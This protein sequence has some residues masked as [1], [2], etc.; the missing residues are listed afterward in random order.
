VSGKALAAG[1]SADPEPVASAIPLSDF[2][3]DPKL[4]VCWADSTTPKSASQSSPGR[5]A[6]AIA[7][8]GLENN[9]GKPA[10]KGTRRSGKW[11]WGRV[12]FRQDIE[13]RP[14]FF[15]PT[16]QFFHAQ[17]FHRS[18]RSCWPPVNSSVVPAQWKFRRAGLPNRYRIAT[19]GRVST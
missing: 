15:T 8:L 19:A 6:I 12:A 2:F 17:F 7:K 1:S 10:R 16:T 11:K 14:N 4:P 9:H 3:A 5:T 18:R 13:T